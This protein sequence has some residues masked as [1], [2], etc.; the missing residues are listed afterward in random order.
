MRWFAGSGLL[1]FWSAGVP[2]RCLDG[3]FVRRLPARTPHSAWHYHFRKL[4]CKSKKRGVINND[5]RSD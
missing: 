1:L 5:L 2:W 3:G 4:S